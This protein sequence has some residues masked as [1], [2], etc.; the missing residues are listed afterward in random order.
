[1]DQARLEDVA[2]MAAIE[3]RWNL[4]L[5]PQSAMAETGGLSGLHG[6]HGLR[7]L[8]LNREVCCLISRFNAQLT[9]YLLAYSKFLSQKLIP[10]VSKEYAPAHAVWNTS[11]MYV[12]AVVVCPEYTGTGIGTTLLH[13]F[14]GMAQKAGCHFALTRIAVAPQANARSLRLFARVLHA[15]EIDRRYEPS[16]DI[17]WGLFVSEKLQA[18]R[19]YRLR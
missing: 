7:E 5:L 9:G 10:C 12:K 2:D 3:S 13:A 11:Y 8:L 15:E 4:N 17:M 6:E 1:M 14:R 19:A 16:C 18:D